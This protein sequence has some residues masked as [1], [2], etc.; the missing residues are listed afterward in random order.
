ML[1]QYI[2][3]AFEDL[4]IIGTLYEKK[5]IHRVAIHL[6]DVIKSYTSTNNEY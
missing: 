1:S 6:I 4:R 5:K 3:P 2:N